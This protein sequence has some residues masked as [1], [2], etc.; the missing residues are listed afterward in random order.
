MLL[1]ILSSLGGLGRHAAAACGECQ[2]PPVVPL[3]CLL[4][5]IRSTALLGGRQHR[6]CPEDSGTFRASCQRPRTAA[7]ITS[8]GAGTPVHTSNDAAPCATR[9]SRPSTTRAP[10]SWAARAV[11]VAG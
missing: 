8:T 9:T 6:S 11:A 5:V 7:R 1:L 3:S 10:R 4:R 2:R